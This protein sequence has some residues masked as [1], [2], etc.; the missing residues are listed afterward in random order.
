M[1]GNWAEA[2]A[3]PIRPNEILPFKSPA[4]DADCE[5]LFLENFKQRR[6][7]WNI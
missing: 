1:P 7:L 6:K 2:A 5:Y 3:P 4:R